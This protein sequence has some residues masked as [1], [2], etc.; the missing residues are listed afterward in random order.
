MGPLPTHLVI[1][2]ADVDQDARDL[3]GERCLRCAGCDRDNT[4]VRLRWVL[5]GLCS[6]CAVR[7]QSV[8]VA[9]PREQ[10]AAP[11]PRPRQGE[12]FDG[13]SGALPD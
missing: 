7:V 3:Y 4:S 12:M 5:P 9:A 6:E 2:P 11:P 10:P 13:W 1:T 8:T